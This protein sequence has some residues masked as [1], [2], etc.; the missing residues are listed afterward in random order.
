MKKIKFV[1]LSKE[2]ELVVPAPKPSVSYLP[3]WYKNLRVT[4]GNKKFFDGQIVNKTVKSCI[5]FFDAFSA[6]YIQE[7]WCDIEVI[8]G[9]GDSV[10]V[11]FSY[12]PSI[13]NIRESANV[14]IPNNFY[15]VEFVWQIPWMPKTSRGYSSLF[16]QPLNNMDLP[17]YNTSGIIDSDLFYSSIITKGGYP[18]YIQKDFEGTIPCGTPMYQIIPIKRDSWKSFKEKYDEELNFKSDYGVHKV[19]LGGYKKFIHQ[20]KVYK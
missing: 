8:R 12:S 6:G 4:D 15:N 20:K 13:I 9:R 17:F 5:P 19:F 3:D 14:K 10:E 11:H 7:T 1:P 2:A 16:I 18:F